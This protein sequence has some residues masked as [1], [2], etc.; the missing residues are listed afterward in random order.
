MSHARE[1]RINETPF[2]VIRIS[3]LV[4]VIRPKTKRVK[5]D[6]IRIN[7]LCVCKSR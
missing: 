3:V 4:R 5:P 6:R 1:I 2:S 7:G